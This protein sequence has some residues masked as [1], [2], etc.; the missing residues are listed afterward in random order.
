MVMPR[1]FSSSRRSGSVP[2]KARDQ[3][4]LPVVDMSGGADDYG[5]HCHQFIERF[6]ELRCPSWRILK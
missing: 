4:T 6:L 5:L 1:R 2:V 3:R